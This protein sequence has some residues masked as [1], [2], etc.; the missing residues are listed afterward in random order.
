VPSRWLETGPL[1][2]LEAK[3]VGLP[4]IGSNVGGI[5]E[6]VREPED[7]LL[8]PPDNVQAWGDAILR[9][10]R[11]PSLSAR[12]TGV[13]VRTMG[14]VATDMSTTYREACEPMRV[15]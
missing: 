6:L 14:D 7:G 1:V 5:A 8:V 13:K 3:A 15:A 2:V 11:C 12:R 4:I 10:M 9:L